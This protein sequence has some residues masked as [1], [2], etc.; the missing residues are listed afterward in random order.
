LDEDQQNQGIEEVGDRH[1]V[2]EGDP[3]QQPAFGRGGA[4][5]ATG[6]EEITAVDENMGELKRPNRAARPQ[7]SGL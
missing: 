4:R 1:A 3:L 2:E 5:W 7:E 6:A